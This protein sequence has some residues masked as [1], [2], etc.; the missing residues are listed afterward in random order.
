LAYSNKVFSIALSKPLFGKI[1]DKIDKRIQIIA[2]LFVLGLSFGIIGFF[3]NAVWIVFIGAIFGLCLSF[4]TI[5]T[6]AYLA[7]I[8]DKSMLGTS[9]SGLNSIMDIGHSFGP[10]IT[11]II[12]GCVSYSAGFFASFMLSILGII[13]FSFCN[14]SKE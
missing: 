2:G 14:Y 12:I 6:S 3:S 8:A 11:G 4:S 5:A 10:L 13:I 9:F 7:D 1:A